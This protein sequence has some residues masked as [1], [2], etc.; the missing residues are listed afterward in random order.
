MDDWREMLY[1]KTLEEELTGL[2]RRRGAD[3][4]CTPADLQALLERLYELEGADWL[5]R[6][7]VQ[8]ITLSAQIAAH[9][10]FISEWRAEKNDG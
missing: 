1:S 8:S 3:S 7:E 5:G 2:E 6:G 4:G 9:E 10:R